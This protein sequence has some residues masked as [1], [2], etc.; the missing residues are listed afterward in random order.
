V[1]AN[2]VGMRHEYFSPGTDRSAWPTM[3]IPNNWYLTEV[4]DYDGTVWFATSFVAPESMKGKRLTLKFGAVDYFANVWLNGAYLGKHEGMFLPFEFDVTGKVKFGAENVLVVRDDSP[5]DPTEYLLVRDP[6]NLSQPASEP[7]K[8]HWAKDLTLIKGHMTDAMHR[9]G[10]MTKFRQDGNSGGIWQDVELIAETDVQIKGVKIYCKI[11]EEDGSALVS[12]DLD[13]NNSSGKMIETSVTMLVKPKNFKGDTVIDYTRPLQLQP[14]RTTVKL[15]KTIAKPELWWTWDFGKPNLYTAEFTIAGFA[16]LTETFGVKKIEKD[17]SGK[18]Y[19][20][21]KRIFLRGMRYISSLWISEATAKSYKADLDKIL[22]MKCNSIRIGSHVEKDMFYDMCD[23]MG[24][25]VW[26]V[27]PLH[28]CYSD[29]DDVIERAAPQMRDMVYMLYNHASMGMWSVFKEPKIYGLPNKPNNYGR[30]CQIMYE[31]ARTVDPVRWV[32]TGDY[33]E[34]VQN[35]MIGCCAPGDTDMKRKEVKPQI[36]EFGAMA[37]P[38]IETLKT[39]IPADKLWPPDWDTWEYWGLFY[40]LMFDFGKV[41]MGN[42]LQEFIDNSQVYEAK[43]IKEQIEFLRQKKYSPVC[44]MYLYYW[45]DACPFIGSGLFDYYRRPY[46]AYESMKAV[47]TPVLISLEWNKDPY[48]IGWEKIWWPN[49]TFVGKLWVTNDG[50][51]VERATLTWKLVNKGTGAVVS[52]GEKVVALTAD[53]SQVYEEFSW[54][55]PAGSRGQYQVLMD[56]TGARGKVLS[57]NYFDL[58]V[59]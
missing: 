41:E 35:L 50:D 18:W 5:R 48:I 51:A 47:Y 21:N 17:D 16:A 36:V 1:D 46:K 53:S 14:G 9:P 52:S 38:D 31:M 56:V 7:Y 44:S 6:F 45:S 34:G 3:K 2:G 26:Q 29:S 49:D 42:S 10:A 20:N 11:V 27:F 30:L 32:H 13:V 8:R 59:Y 19:L 22:D 54:K 28:Y 39:I 15:V 23:E 43:A 37:I 40:N 58:T 33:E 55:V 12:V 25:L 57:S 4:G 24:F